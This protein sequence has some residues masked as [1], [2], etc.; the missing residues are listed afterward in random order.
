M[1]LCKN[2]LK[3]KLNFKVL[4]ISILVCI[5]FVLVGGIDIEKEILSNNYFNFS[6][7]KLLLK[8]N[9]IYRYIELFKTL[10]SKDNT[11]NYLFFS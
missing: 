9:A 7:K 3:L 4:L 6:T 1:K 11:L 10:P 5:V 8:D 2:L